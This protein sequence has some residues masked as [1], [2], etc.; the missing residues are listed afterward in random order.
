MSKKDKIDPLALVAKLAAEEQRLFEGTILAPIVDGARVQ[1]KV[2][3]IVYEL[4]VDDKFDGWALLR[5][6]A[7][8]KARVVEPASPALVGKYLQL[9]ARVRLILLQQFDRRWF[10]LAASTSDTRIQLSGPVPLH[11]A[12]SVKSFDTVNSRFDGSAFWFEGV[13]RRR[14]PAISRTLNS[15]LNDKVK[16]EDLRC[17]GVVPQERLAYRMLWL[18]KYGDDA[19]IPADDAARVGLALRHA[20]AQLLQFTYQE[21]DRAT[22][23]ISVDG[24]TR[25]VSI[26]PS[27]LTVL[28]AG[29]C[30]SGR[31]FDFDLTSLVSVFREAARDGEDY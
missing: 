15:A 7:P 11:L 8:G 2:Q 21:Q 18:S 26:R 23:S 31:D 13:D 12:Q 5:M 17:P 3:G 6:T 14:D 10:A 19:I 20:G 27:D 30:L 28:S 25:N 16:P 22:V 9:F 4:S 24:I 29:I 1:I